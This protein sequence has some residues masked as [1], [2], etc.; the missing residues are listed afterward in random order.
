ME[1]N[2]VRK[3]YVGYAIMYSCYSSI[4]ASKM[5]ILRSHEKYSQTGSLGNNIHFCLKQD[6]YT[7]NPNDRKG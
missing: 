6:R 5:V 2:F 3:C 7:T 4:D 1:K